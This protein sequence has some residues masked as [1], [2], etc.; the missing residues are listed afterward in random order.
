MVINS[1]TACKPKFY[2]RNNLLHVRYKVDRAIEI[3]DAEKEELHKKLEYN[4]DKQQTL[5]DLW[6]FLS[7]TAARPII[8]DGIA[9]A[10]EKYCA[11]K[12]FKGK[13]NGQ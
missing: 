13:D 12:G 1:E 9:Y 8:E 11:G 2:V 10:T 4:A 3:T 5:K 7:L 6:C